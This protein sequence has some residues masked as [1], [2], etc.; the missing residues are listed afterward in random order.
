MRRLV[1]LTL[2]G[3]FAMGCSGEGSSVT[4]ADAISLGFE[5]VTCRG[6]S[7]GPV[8]ARPTGGSVREMQCEAV[9]AAILALS[10]P[11]QGLIDVGALHRDSIAVIAVELRTSE[12][13]YESE[14]YLMV[15]LELPARPYNAYVELSRSREVLDEGW[16]PI[17]LRY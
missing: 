7:R 8:F 1:R 16:A 5:Q 15:T 3:C 12:P 10:D 11:E 13:P 2:V 14:S 6:M 4:K 17:G 9:E